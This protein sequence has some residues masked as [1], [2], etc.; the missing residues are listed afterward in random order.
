MPNRLACVIETQ[1][2]LRSVSGRRH[3]RVGRGTDI[4]ANSHQHVDGRRGEF[5]DALDIAEV[6]DHDQADPG[7][8][9]HAQLGIGL[10]VAMQEQISTVK[11][12]G[13]RHHDLASTSNVDTNALL[14]HHS[15]NRSGR[16]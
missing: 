2:E 16:K 1:A 3:R 14:R 9:H 12:G 8:E 13:Q 10:G 7:I 15:I 4:G 11:T 6:I 5:L